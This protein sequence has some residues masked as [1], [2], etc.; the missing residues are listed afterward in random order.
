MELLHK[1]FVKF[2]SPM[3]A[4][5]ALGILSAYYFGLTGTYWAVT[6]EFTRWGGHILQF[7]GVDTQSLGY[8]KIIGLSG[9]P[10]DRIDGV[11]IIGMFFGAFIAASFANNIKLRMPQ[12]NI[13]IIQALL[14]GMC[15]RISQRDIER[16]S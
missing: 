6:G 14:G 2:Y 8:F 1:C 7:L 15:S 5:V 12:S 9:T 3:P 11:M 16:F 13:R 10:L 4:I